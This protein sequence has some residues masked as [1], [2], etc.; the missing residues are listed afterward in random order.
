MTDSKPEK[1]VYQRLLLPIYAPTLLNSL[2]LN[3]F[4]VLMPLYALETGGGAAFAALLIGLRGIG[5]LLF[6][7]PVGILLSR[8]GDKRVLILGLLAMMISAVLF[9]LANARWAMSIAAIVSGMGFAAW[10]I[11]RQ[12]Y[13]TDSSNVGERGRAMTMMAGTMRLGGFIGPA[14][15]A[16]VAEVFGFKVAF[17]ALATVTAGA[18]VLVMSF[19]RD[20]RPERQAGFAHLSRV[21]EIVTSHAR[22]LTTGGFASIG[23]QLMRSGRVLLI[24]LVGYFLELN[25]AAIGLIISLS[26]MIDAAL[27]YPVGVVMDRYG[28]K[29][30]GVPSLILFGLSLALLPLSQGYYSLLAVALLSGVANG[31]STGLLLTLGSD[32]APPAVRGEFLGIWRLVGDLGHSAGPFMIGALIEL[33]TLGVAA[34]TVAGIGLLG[35]AVL[36]GLVD[37]TL[38]RDKP[39]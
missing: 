22:V 20:I 36:Y 1:S 39:S 21:R 28:R 10:M 3:A 9:A 33:A 27:F 7:L 16:V 35:A 25:I 2:S 24:P 15:G 13:I 31:L 18:T 11:G 26:A 5:M 30:T 37:E 38:R 23:L 34:T 6:D 12:S 8:L 29:W 32:L 14:L 4:L 19:T 17:I